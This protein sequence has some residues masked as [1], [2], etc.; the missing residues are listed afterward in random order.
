MNVKQPIGQVKLR[1]VRV[2]DELWDRLTAQAK[3]EGATVSGLLRRVI[4]EYLDRADVRLEGAVPRRTGRR[5]ATTTAE[6]TEAAVARVVAPA[7][8][9]ND[10][11]PR[12][13]KAWVK[14]GVCQTCRL[15]GDRK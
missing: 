9:V 13:P 6:A 3:R 4:A 1:N 10:V 14:D 12:H 15:L 8:L 5:A 2:V 7:G 11:C